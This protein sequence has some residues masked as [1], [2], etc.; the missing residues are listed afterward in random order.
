MEI[1]RNTSF[2]LTCTCGRTKTEV[3]KSDGVIN[4]ILQALRMLCKGYYRI[5]IV[6]S[7]SCQ[8][9]ERVNAHF[10]SKTDKKISENDH[11]SKVGTSKVVSV[12]ARN[13]KKLKIQQALPN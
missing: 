3:F 8:V 4:H 5:S 1:I 2:S 11:P 10:V 6:L 9:D 12:F 13:N 7:V